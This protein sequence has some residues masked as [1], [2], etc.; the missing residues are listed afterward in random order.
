VNPPSLVRAGVKF[1][2]SD[3][4][5]NHLSHWRVSGTYFEACSC[6]AI[7]PCR[8]QGGVRAGTR[9]TYGV[10]DFALSW[11][12]LNG[13]F[14]DVD[15]SDRFVVMAGSYTDDEPNKP[16]RVILYVDERSSEEQFVALT[17][18]FLGRAGGTAFVN[19]GK[20]IGATYAIR[21]AVI[22]LDHT[23]RRW[24]VRASTWVEVRAARTVPSEL[25]V[26]C[27]IPGHDQSG[28]EVIADACRVDDA[29]L[30]FDLRGRCG[31][32]SHF[33]YSSEEGS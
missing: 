10:C 25:G 32:E 31:F 9:S 23:P 17:D 28:N 15:L 27:G 11:R 33:D 26:T 6:D 22:E 21:R 20:R 12:I 3:T 8:K 7:C 2:V 16:W 30:H 5:G 14:S 29:P 1:D 4:I 19:F 24:F 18:I 13:S